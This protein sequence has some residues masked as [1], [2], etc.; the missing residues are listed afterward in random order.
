M[1]IAQSLNAHPQKVRALGS[2]V[3]YYQRLGEHEQAAILAGAIIG[4]PLIDEPLFKPVCGQLEAAL[5]GGRY[6][7][8]LAQ[9]KACSL[10]DL[11]SEVVAFLA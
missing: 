6:R 2:V 5:G 8:A 11:A 4:D 9:G 10:D 7:E 3:A 1:T